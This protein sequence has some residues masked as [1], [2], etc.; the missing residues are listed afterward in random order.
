[1]LE[2]YQEQSYTYF[3]EHWL[4][5]ALD[6]LCIC[7]FLLDIYAQFAGLGGHIEYNTK[8]IAFAV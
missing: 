8:V 6:H 2:L 7:E 3:F 5:I 4:N 1:M